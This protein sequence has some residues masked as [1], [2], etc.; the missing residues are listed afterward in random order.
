MEV[1]GKVRKTGRKED[2][3]KVLERKDKKREEKE[4]IRVKER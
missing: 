3:R 1:K 4:S 2:R